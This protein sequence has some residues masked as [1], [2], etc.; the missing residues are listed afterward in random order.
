MS[1]R[2]PGTVPVILVGLALLVGCTKTGMSSRMCGPA[3]PAATPA[4][5]GSL[6]IVGRI[7]TMD[8]P[9]VAEALLIERGTVA[10]VGP[11]DEMVGLACDGIPVIDIGDG[12]AY[13]GFID[14]HAHWIGDR[15]Y[16][17]VDSAAIA[18]AIHSLAAHDSKWPLGVNPVLPTQTPPQARVP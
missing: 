8:E 13:P 4:D 5:G 11:R 9:P 12:V 14:A 17:G 15:N 2:L 10:A 7:V 6:M 16:Y 1:A 18:A 3:D